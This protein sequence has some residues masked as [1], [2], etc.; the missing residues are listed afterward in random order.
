VKVNVTDSGFGAP[1]TVLSGPP[2]VY[3][4]LNVG[5]A[6]SC[7]RVITPPSVH[8][9]VHANAT[10][11]LVPSG[12]DVDC[13][14]H[15]VAMAFVMRHSVVG[16]TEIALSISWKL[17]AMPDPALWEIVTVWPATAIVPDRAAPA[18]L[19]AT[20]AVT[21]PL[22]VPDAGLTVMN[23]ALLA[24]VQ[25]HVPPV[26]TVIATAPPLVLTEV[27]AGDTVKPHTFAGVL[28]VSVVE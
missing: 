21:V 28:N 1:S 20:V 15:V 8:C 19:D 17:A 2:H 14:V 18:A 26:V 22:P 23:D 11:P 25:V 5:L 13:T 3:V 24:A 27:A 4:K 16:F 7:V 9:T 10:S 6:L 12:N